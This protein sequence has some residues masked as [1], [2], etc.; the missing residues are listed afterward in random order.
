MVVMHYFAAEIFIIGS[1][2]GEAEDVVPAAMHNLSPADGLC[3]VIVVADAQRTRAT[4]L[5]THCGPRASW[6]CMATT[7]E[8]LLFGAAHGEGAWRPLR[9]C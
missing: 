8:S 6:S 3:I 1:T 5:G 4:T 9:R 7:A 2:S